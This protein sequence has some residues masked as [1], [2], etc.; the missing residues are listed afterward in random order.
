MSVGVDS[1]GMTLPPIVQ[2]ECM[3]KE[4]VNADPVPSLDKGACRAID[5]RRSGS[6]V[7]WKVS[8]T[9]TLVGRGEGEITYRSPTAYDGWMTLETS[10]VTI[11]S[12]VQARRVGGC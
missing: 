11:R 8:C 1:P 6:K 9:G 4:Q 2:S 3:S 5:I 12:K 10:G 7:T